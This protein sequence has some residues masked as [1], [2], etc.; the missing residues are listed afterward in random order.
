MSP[1]VQ[2]PDNEMQKLIFH[3]VPAHFE[4]IRLSTGSSWNDI[5]GFLMLIKLSVSCYG[6]VYVLVFYLFTYEAEL[7]TV[8][9]F[10]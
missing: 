8:L 5:R 4:L 7:K 10:T 2:F 9:F 1:N 3:F 6:S